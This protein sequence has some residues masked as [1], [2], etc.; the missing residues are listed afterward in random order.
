[1]LPRGS[2]LIASR[3]AVAAALGVLLVALLTP[4]PSAA[5][6]DVPLP[7]GSSDLQEVRTTEVLEEGVTL[8]S[9]VRGSK[10]AR[11]RRIATTTRGPWRIQV[12]TIDPAV[13][14]GSLRP[15]YGADLAAVEPVSEL[16]AQAGALA[17]VNASFFTFTASE[18]YPGDP[19]GLGVHDGELLSEPTRAVGEVALLIGADNR[20]RMDKLSWHGRMVHRTTLEELPLDAVN[21][22]PV[23]PLGCRKLANPTRCRKAGEVIHLT[24]AFS[25][26]TPS[27]RGVEV[28][29]GSDGCVLRREKARG[30]R[31]RHGQTSLQ[32]TGRESRLLWRLTREGCLDRTTELTDRRGVSLDTERWRYGVNGRFRLTARGRN[33]A[34][35]ESGGFFA[36]HPR[37][38]AGR[39]GT[40]QIMLV[41][42][43][44][45]Q[46]TSVGATLQEAAEVALALGLRDSVNLDGGGST[47]MVAGGVVT[48]SPSGGR[49][50]A[51]GDALVYVPA[52]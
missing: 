6:E 46:R 12:L 31:L 47:T 50:R 32:A 14:A 44:G 49:E 22:P 1:M 51:V 28:V 42:I 52:P 27:G 36:R 38:F 4:S 40:G 3:R 37:T 8:T 13:A 9:I 33:V 11:W 5:R 10:P 26:W 7:L 15:V 21:H 41:T 18:R 45:R 34:P 29:L 24:R 39:T 17:A 2:S 25:R 48:N 30:T 20:V 19:V 35:D 43:D 16:A 23:V